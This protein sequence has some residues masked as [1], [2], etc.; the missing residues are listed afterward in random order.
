[1][2][3]KGFFAQL[4]ATTFEMALKWIVVSLS[5]LTG[6][7]PPLALPP[8]CLVVNRKTTKGD[9]RGVSSQCHTGIQHVI[10]THRAMIPSLALESRQN[11]SENN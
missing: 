11:G 5:F 7:T 9:T 4:D 6:L 1:M 10:C 3:L 8:Y 2:C